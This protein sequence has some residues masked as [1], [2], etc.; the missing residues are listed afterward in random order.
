[1]KGS[2]LVK[3][4]L[5]LFSLLIIISLICFPFIINDQKSTWYE[6]ILNKN[7]AVLIYQS[8]SEH[9]EVG[10][11]VAYALHKL[12]PDIKLDVYFPAHELNCFD[13]YIEEYPKNIR[14]ISSLI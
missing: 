7:L 1:M 4:I 11:G 12:N 5:V 2:K 3:I 10:T 6:K 13:T 14:K 9:T 8:R